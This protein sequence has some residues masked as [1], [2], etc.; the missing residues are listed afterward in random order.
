M[1][2]IDLPA[3]ITEYRYEGYP[4][5]KEL[6]AGAPLP[7]SGTSGTDGMILP[8]EPHDKII[9]L[10]PSVP[11][12][13]GSI[14]GE[15][16]PL[17][18]GADL[19]RICSA[20]L[21]DVI[22]QLKQL[23]RFSDELDYIA[24]II[25]IALTYI[26]DLIPT[27][28][29]IFYVGFSGAKGSGKSTATSI[30]ARVSKDG[31]KLEGVTYSALAHA[32][33]NKMTLC[34]DEFDAQSEKCPE[35]ETIVRQ[36]IDLDAQYLKSIPDGKGRWIQDVVPCGG[37]KFLNWRDPID[38]ALLQ[39]ILVIKMAPNASTRMIVNNEAPERFTS[40]L[41]C[42]FA[43]QA[44]EV[45]KRCGPQK[46]RELIED[47]DGHL[48]RKLDDLLSKL[49]RQKQ[50]AFHMLVICEIFGWSLDDTIKRLIEKQP[51][52]EEY[53][54]YKDLVVEIHQLNKDLKKDESPVVLE[55][56]KF[57]KDMS[58]RIKEKGMYPLKSRGHLSWVGL[59]QEC[60][61]ID[62]I[63]D[64]KLSQK[65]GKRVLIF[66]ERVQKSLGVFEEQRTLPED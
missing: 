12:S 13:V 4:F 28:S 3:N 31:I 9:P 1:T 51:E 49:P 42:W 45:H 5:L 62:G 36:G 58:E 38:D 7:R 56:V 43:A 6:E 39:R 19:N 37:M 41:K 53:E 18:D 17:E 25:G 22:E 57:K 34:L 44:A 27:S 11:L 29:R 65:G 26:I 20:S 35:L 21:A 23:V 46:V 40:P 16:N 59:R 30:C 33:K 10:V 60:G 64:K 32:C 52:D 55:L 54:D 24:V 8:T 66:D 15:S 63:S 2:P 61:F 48:T 14:A 50:K 47:R